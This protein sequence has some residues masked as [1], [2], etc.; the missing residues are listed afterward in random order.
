MRAL[1]F[2][3]GTH[4]Y[5]IIIYTY[6]IITNNISMFWKTSL[7]SLCILELAH[8]SLALFWSLCVIADVSLILLCR[9]LTGQS[10]CPTTQQW[11]FPVPVARLSLNWSSNGGTTPTPWQ[12]LLEGLAFAAVYYYIPSFGNARYGT[13]CSCVHY[14]KY[15]YCLFTLHQGKGKWELNEVTLKY[16]LSDFN[17]SI[18]KPLSSL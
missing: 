14:T 6:I 1:R 9:F 17:S 12:W 15:G 10:T 2:W 5:Y 16:N 7:Y 18:C 11:T 8:Y 13:T 3:L 4:V